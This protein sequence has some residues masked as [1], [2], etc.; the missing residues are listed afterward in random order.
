MFTRSWKLATC[1]YP[2]SKKLNVLMIGVRAWL[3]I[4]VPVL[5]T[6]A[7]WMELRS[8]LCTDQFFHI[9]LVKLL[10]T[11]KSCST[12]HWYVLKSI[13]GMSH[14]VSGFL[15]YISHSKLSYACCVLLLSIFYHHKILFVPAAQKLLGTVVKR[16]Q[17]GSVGNRQPVR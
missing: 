2:L 17:R 9:K 8:E 12:K 4:S 6:G 15:Y 11:G 5:P 1:Q 16:S 3:T 7:F 13:C 14:N 10:Q